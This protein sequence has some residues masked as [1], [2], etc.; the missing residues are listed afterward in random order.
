LRWWKGREEGGLEDEREE[1]ALFFHLARCHQHRTPPEHLAKFW[2]GDPHMPESN[3]MGADTKGK[4][5]E[6]MCTRR[7]GWGC[8]G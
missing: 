1:G 2:E 6:A 5:L 4:V 7:K 3:T 8:G